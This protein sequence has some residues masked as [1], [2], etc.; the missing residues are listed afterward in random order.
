M[1]LIKFEI[2]VGDWNGRGKEGGKGRRDSYSVG[3]RDTEMRLAIDDKCIC[4]SLYGL[5]SLDI[6][7]VRYIP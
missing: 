6:L 4:S 1:Q 7:V 3:I 2:P 5:L